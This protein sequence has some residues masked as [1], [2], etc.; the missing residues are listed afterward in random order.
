MNLK[1]L[2][3]EWQPFCLSLNG[4]IYNKDGSCIP[5][6]EIYMIQVHS[7]LVAITWIK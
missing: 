5:Y 2:F 6:W 4:V 7:N 1:M 3:A